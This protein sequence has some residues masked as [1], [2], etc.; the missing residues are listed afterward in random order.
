MLLRSAGAR[1]G[2]GEA[3][4]EYIVSKEAR[5]GIKSFKSPDRYSVKL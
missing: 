3:R 5:I 4:L 1:G 2:H